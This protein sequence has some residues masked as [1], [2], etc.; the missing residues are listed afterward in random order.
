MKKNLSIKNSEIEN[1]DPRIV[2][3]QLNKAE[4]TKQPK[5]SS[6]RIKIEARAKDASNYS[7]TDTKVN[8]FLK[9]TLAVL[10]IIFSILTI[11]YI[12]IQIKAKNLGLDVSTND[13]INLIE[14]QINAPEKEDPTKLI[15][16]DSSGF[17]TNVLLV[18]IDTRIGE[19][20]YLMNTDT[21]IL[22]SYNHLSGTIT[23][24]SIPR[25]TIVKNVNNGYSYKINTFYASAEVAQA[26]TGLENLT[27]TVEYY[28]GQ[29]IQYSAMIN[30]KA[31]VQ[32][33]D[34]I[35]GIEVNVEKSFTDFNYPGNQGY[36]L[37]FQAGVQTMDGNRAL[38]FARSRQSM[39][40]MEGSDFARAKR[41]Q[42]I[43]N[44]VKNK[45]SS[46]DFNIN[47]TKLIEI[48]NTLQENVKFSG[49]NYDDINGAIELLKQDKIK[50]Q[51]SII[52]DPNI[53]G[54]TLLYETL[55]EDLGYAIL[56]Y[57]GFNEYSNIQNFIANNLTYPNLFHQ[58]PTI[59]IYDCG[60]NYS[61]L[62]E[63]QE[64]IQNNTNGYLQ[65]NNMGTCSESLTNNSLVLLNKNSNKNHLE[66]SKSELKNILDI[67]I[68]MD[69][70]K[71]NKIQ[72]N[73]FDSSNNSDLII[74]LGK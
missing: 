66:L 63:M 12:Y 56:P 42:L 37:S 46:L 62:I 22:A 33:I 15:K 39:D 34:L 10:L 7:P 6:K 14:N 17:K 2:V 20:S 21:I 73:F 26:G 3:R 8:F 27:N 67:P 55:R 57:Q 36:P 68:E 19:N 61:K 64:K 18:G 74:L 65:I 16:K 59:S 30:Y 1:T 71:V 45:V 52:L 43:I 32:L 31:F 48:A 23:L 69:E 41:Q 44:A 35:G 13:L 72:N 11:S 54:G 38:Q 40:N 60:N 9:I 29:E 51:Y 50:A 28:T 53:E 70:E 58:K 49:Y 25:D 47:V 5:S 24:I 4:E